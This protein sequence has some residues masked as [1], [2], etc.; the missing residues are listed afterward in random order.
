MIT[1]GS[2][3]FAY[4]VTIQTKMIAPIY[5]SYMKWKDWWNLSALIQSGGPGVSFNSG[6]S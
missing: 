3:S 2:G 5:S 1:W 4:I 6:I